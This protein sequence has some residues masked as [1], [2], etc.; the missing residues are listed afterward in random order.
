H[1]STAVTLVGGSIFLAVALVP[2]LGDFSEESRK[3]L[4]DNVR[5][6]WKKI[7]HGGIGVFLL[8]GFYNYFRAMPKHEGDGLYHALVGTKI[9]VA[10]VIFFLASVLVGRSPKFES[11]R[12]NPS[13]VLR[14][15]ILLSMLIIVVSGFLKI[16]GV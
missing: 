8:S 2:S 16:R 15:M 6:R 10:L 3:M 4:M 12:Q 5:G 14:L 11:W 13:G 9:L 7:V 1:I